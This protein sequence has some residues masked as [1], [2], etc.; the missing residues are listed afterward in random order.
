MS[1][2]D[3]FWDAG[4]SSAQVS[5]MGGPNHDVV[6]LSA[7]L[8]PRARVLDLGCGEGRNAFYLAGLGHRVHALDISAAG[9]AKLLGLAGDLDLTA[10]VGDLNTYSVDGEW[11]LVMA[12]GVIDYLDNATWRHLCADIRA[13]TAPGGFNAYTCMLFTAEFPEPDEFRRAG[14]KHSLAPYELVSTYDGWQICRHDRYVKWDQHP[15]IPIHCH[16]VDKVVARRPAPDMP[17]L[18]RTPVPIGSVTL[19]RT[20]FDAIDLGMPAAE[21]RDRCGPPD[22]VDTYQ[23]PGR[24]YGVADDP[25]VDGYTLDLWFYGRAV[26]YVINGR[27]W[28]RALYES[29]PQRVRY[30]TLR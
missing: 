5:T 9:I 23:I 12:H 17:Q 21:L 2:P 1:L 29:E 24:Q 4:Y 6:E 11:D 10:E 22:V 27:V 19:D 14:F 26:M 16:P 25:V 18:V 20:A 13:H 15:G 8:P 3:A 28:G 7:A 30:D